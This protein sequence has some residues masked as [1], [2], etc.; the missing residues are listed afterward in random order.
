MTLHPV[1]VAKA[2]EIAKRRGV[3]REEAIRE[4]LGLYSYLTQ[5]LQDEDELHLS[6]DGE[7]FT[8]IEW[9]YKNTCEWQHVD[10]GFYSTECGDWLK[11][12]EIPERCHQCGRKRVPHKY[13][14]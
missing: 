1:M 7:V 14:D 9:K 3:T 5:R 10:Q 12:D 2:E 4:A 6:R 11:P 8:S 13:R